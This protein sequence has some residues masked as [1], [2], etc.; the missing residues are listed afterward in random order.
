[1]SRHAGRWKD[2]HGAHTLRRRGR[3]ADGVAL[4]LDIHF[5]AHAVHVA[6]SALHQ[7]SMNLP[8][9][10]AVRSKWEI[11]HLC[12]ATCSC[13]LSPLLREA[14][15]SGMSTRQARFFCLSLRGYIGGDIRSGGSTQPSASIREGAAHRYPSTRACSCTI[16]TQ[17]I[18]DGIL[19]RATTRL[20][21]C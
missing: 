12:Y 21:F 16:R 2:T 15:F 18:G 11:Q 14:R 19:P 1:M 4:V 3:H 20:G 17:P 7:R 13:T 8:R 9:G 10:G 6:L 5:A